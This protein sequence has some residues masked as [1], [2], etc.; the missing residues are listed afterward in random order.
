M[1]TV[2][3]LTAQLLHALVC[4]ERLRIDLERAIV[5]E[6]LGEL[7]RGQ[8]REGLLQQAADTRTPGC[9]GG[10]VQ[11]RCRHLV[12][13]FAAR[14]RLA[15]ASSA[16]SSASLSA[17]P[18]TPQLVYRTH[19]AICVRVRP[20][21]VARWDQA[22]SSRRHR[23]R[24]SSPCMPRS[25]ASV[26]LNNKELPGTGRP[27]APRVGI[28]KPDQ[29]A[30][31]FVIRGLPHGK[32]ITIAAAAFDAAGDVIG[33]IG[34]MTSEIVTALPLP[35]PLLWAH[36]ARHAY[37]LGAPMLV[38]RV[39]TEVQKAIHAITPSLAPRSAASSSL[40][41]ARP[42]PC[43]WRRSS[44]SRSPSTTRHSRRAPCRQCVQ[45]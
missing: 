20:F 5:G 15:R 14:T 21:Y 10:R 45:H 44:S 9:A 3:A 42:R 2:W 7:L 16:S 6:L 37:Q 26:W 22:A 18:K 35:R 27:R 30:V 19:E 17:V 23:C 12:G 34:G 41:A 25:R 29:L 40:A 33:G 31:C 4:H 43:P 13:H 8:S 39:L 24:P 28:D 1:I 32:P 36:F 11:L 38:R